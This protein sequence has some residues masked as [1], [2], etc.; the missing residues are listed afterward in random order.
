M[1]LMKNGM[2]LDEIIPENVVEEE[3]IADLKAGR[4]DEVVTRC[5]PEPSGYWHIAHVKAWTID[6]E[7][8]MKFGGKTYLRMDDSNPS[9]EQGEFAESYL[10]D[11]AWLGF[12]PDGLIYASEAYFDKVYEI[13]EKEL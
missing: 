8:A 11:L 7:T 5:P 2:D 10:E 12:K 13:I 9:R 4:I 1:N 3:I 6:F